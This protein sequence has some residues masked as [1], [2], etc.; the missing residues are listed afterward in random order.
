MRVCLPSPFSGDVCVGGPG[1]VCWA[2]WCH[3]GGPVLV[4]DLLVWV[5]AQ[6]SPSAAATPASSFWANAHKLTLTTAYEI[7]HVTSLVYS[8]MIEKITFNHQGWLFLPHQLIFGIWQSLCLC[9]DHRGHLTTR[10]INEH[11]CFKSSNG[12]YPQTHTH[13]SQYWCQECSI[14]ISIWCTSC[15]LWIHIPITTASN[16]IIVIRL[17]DTDTL[18]CSL[19]HWGRQTIQHCHCSNEVKHLLS[20]LP[21]CLLFLEPWAPCM[22]RSG[23]E[24]NQR[25][26]TIIIIVT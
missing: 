19:N 1:T 15:G 10:R 7:P 24:N 3:A 8:Q 23:K 12:I 18:R 16:Y 6:L 13:I 4:S 11:T 25:T 9:L 22:R 21:W 2:L 20:W 17:S 26:N 5:Q 14:K